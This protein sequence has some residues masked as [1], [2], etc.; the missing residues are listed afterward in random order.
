MALSMRNNG[1]V[2]DIRLWLD[3]QPI[4]ISAGLGVAALGAIATIVFPLTQRLDGGNAS[5]SLPPTAP[6]GLAGDEILG[7]DLPL[8]GGD[9]GTS[10]EVDAWGV[11]S[12][13]EVLSLTP[14][15]ASEPEPD[16]GRSPSLY[17]D[18]FT[19]TPLQHDSGLESSGYGVLSKPDGI[20]QP[21]SESLIPRP[22]NPL[23][24]DGLTQRTDEPSAT[25]RQNLSDTIQFQTSPLPGTT[26]YQVP[27]ALR[28][29]INLYTQ[30][31]NP[32]FMGQL[33]PTLP[34]T[35]I[36]PQTVPSQALST[37]GLDSVNGYIYSP[38]V[39]PITP[40]GQ[41]PFIVPQNSFAT[42]LPPSPQ[43]TRF[44]GG[45]RGGEFNTFSNP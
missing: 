2:H 29:P 22:L 26:G 36:T 38:S 40:T 44:N 20:G 17:E 6:P 27:Q 37:S 41:P 33:T 42:P 18:L 45:G 30:Q 4:A 9:P 16:E 13:S 25:F 8:A 23:I 5:S 43:S 14:T 31:P 39:V 34:N 24:A 21:P 1:F 7:S 32:S 19:P 11:L 35:L 28:S 3:Q 10:N 12:E 15:D